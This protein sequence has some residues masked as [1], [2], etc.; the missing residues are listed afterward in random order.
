[1]GVTDPE[2]DFAAMFEASIKAKRFDKGQTLEGTIV[3]IGPEVAFVDV[4]G[5]GEATIDVDELK[6]A[7]GDI[8][9]N[10]GD[11]V[12]AVVVS[13]SGGLTLSRTLARGA[14]TDRQLEEAFH[15]GLPVEGKVEREVKGGYEIRIGRSR[16]FCPLSQMDTPRAERQP[17]DGRVYRFRIIEYKDGGRNLVVSRRALIEDEQR[18]AA[19]EIRRSLV[20]GAVVTGRVA[21]VREFGAF[22]DLGGGIQ[23]LLHVSEIGWSRVS[24]PA[25]VLQAGEEITVK[26]LRV[27]DDKQKISLGLKQLSEDPWSRAGETYHVG[28]VHPGRVTRLAEF[29]AFVELEPGVE[30]LAHATTFPPTGQSGGWSRQVP[31]GTTGAFEI[32]SIDLEKKRIGVALLPEGSARATA[33]DQ[34]QIAPGA[35]LRGRVERHEKFGVFVF[36][37]PGRT[38]LIPVSETGVAKDADLGRTFPIGSEVEVVVLEVDAAS[39]RIRLSAKAVQ[40]AEDAAELREFRERGDAAPTDLGSLAEKLQNALKGRTR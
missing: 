15:S 4:G 36:L 19:A 13:T 20:P 32:L 18:A 6:D 31:V 2:D 16:A 9:V 14:A 39:R 29:G 26:V 21:S 38:G 3:A 37:A 25:Q 33:A 40:E 22:V 30:A 27:D 23:G 24:D 5:K 12:Q 8:E 28:Q 17:H 7:D 35:R 10:V 34:P 11:R 1:V